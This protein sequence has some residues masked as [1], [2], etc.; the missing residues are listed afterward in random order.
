MVESVFL[1]NLKK[2]ICAIIIQGTVIVVPQLCASPIYLGLY[3]VG[4]L[5]QNPKGPIDL[6]KLEVRWFE[7]CLGKLE[8]TDFGRRIENT[9]I[10][11]AGKNGVQIKLKFMSSGNRFA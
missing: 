5:C 3:E 7:E 9:G 8:C 6:M 1:F 2:E 11:K 4:F 10:D